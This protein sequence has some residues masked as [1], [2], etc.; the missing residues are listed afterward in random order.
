MD[1]AAPK[2]PQRTG[3]TFTGWNSGFDEITKDTTVTAEYEIS[4]YRYR[5]SSN[6]G[7]SVASQRVEYGSSAEK[8]GDPA[9]EANAFAG[10]YADSALNSPMIFSSAVVGNITLHAKWT[11]TAEVPEVPEAAEVPE[12][13][14]PEPAILLAAG[15][16]WECVTSDFVMLCDAGD[17]G[18]QIYG[19]PP[20]REQSGSNK[21]AAARRASSRVRR[22][23]TQAL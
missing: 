7:G 5:Y 8:A 10:W 9:R 13:Q 12:T 16:T 17:D 15:D 14:M 18:T 21:T 4:S 1:A 22:A 20:I 11:Q 19:L 2:D 3:Y 23:A 6:G